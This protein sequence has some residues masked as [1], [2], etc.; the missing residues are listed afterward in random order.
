MKTKSPKG[1]FVFPTPGPNVIVKS[2]YN[3][4]MKLQH[5]RGFTLI[6]LLVVI[7]II[8]ILASVVLAALGTARD[9]GADASI[10]ST[11]NNMR[12]QAALHYEDNTNYDAFCATL[13]EAE[14]SVDNAG[15]IGSWA[16]TINNSGTDSDAFA[17]S[18]QLSDGNYYCVDSTG[19]AGEETGPALD[20]VCP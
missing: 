20:G 15:G 19:S 16:C 13:T 2:A 14:T 6:E 7:A 17:I 8:G 9:K 10:E 1:D 18:G 11:V 12:G 3:E 5:S 4:I